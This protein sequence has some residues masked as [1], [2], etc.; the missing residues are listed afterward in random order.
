MTPELRLRLA[1]AETMGC[2]LAE[3][4]ERLSSAEYPYWAAYLRERYEGAPQSRTI[5]EP[6]AMMRLFK[7][8]AGA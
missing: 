3:L 1:L 8:L 6:E 5:R 7:Q 4:G 2:T